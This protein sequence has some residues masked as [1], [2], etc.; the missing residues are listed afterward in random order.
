MVE[1]TDSESV[2]NQFRMGSA[3]SCMDDW[4]EGFKT[5]MLNIE[6]DMFLTGQDAS[7]TLVWP[8]PISGEIL[9]VFKGVD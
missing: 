2:S 5:M 4:N 6:T 9:D 7:K 8:N 1:R 3:I